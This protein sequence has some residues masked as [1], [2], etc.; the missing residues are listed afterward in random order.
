VSGPT[1]KPRLELIA[2]MAANG[3]IGRGGQLPWHLPDDLNR[4]K[5]LTLGHPIIMG[6]KTYDSM[7]RPL[8]GRVN[9][10]VSAQLREP[11]HA[12]VKLAS[13]LDEAI[14]LAAPAERVFVIG[15]AMIYESALPRT[16]ILH[17]TELDESVEGDTFFP[18]F[19]RSQWRVLENVV[20][21]RD[22]RHAYAFHF[23][24]FARA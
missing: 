13:S 18:P 23:R 19:D 4:F 10:V 11:P 17:L 16:H 20:H 1:S 9:I 21:D 22:D 3:V 15:G 8:P 12:Q 5:Q 2:A 24:T 7:G 14:A 6:R